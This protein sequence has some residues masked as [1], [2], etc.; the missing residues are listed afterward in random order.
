MRRLN[1]LEDITKVSRAT[2]PG[3]FRDLY[4]PSHWIRYKTCIQPQIFSAL[5]PRSS[6]TPQ[7]SSFF[8]SPYCRSMSSAKDV[9]SQSDITKMKREPDGSFKRLD[10]SFRDT[11]APGTQ[12]EA[13]ASEFKGAFV[14]YLIFNGL[15]TQ[16]ATIFMSR[17]LAV[18]RMKPDVTGVHSNYF[19][20]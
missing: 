14:L 9:T 11:I 12:F 13:D 19:W 5:L 4:G 3:P 6:L 15:I 18:R 16:T 20:T 7:K 17:S 10:A 2:Y 1:K 8:Q